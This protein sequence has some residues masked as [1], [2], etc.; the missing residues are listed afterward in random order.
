[1]EFNLES[2]STGSLTDRPHS[3]S[4]R[5]IDLTVYFNVAPLS[6]MLFTATQAS[7]S[8]RQ[9]N[10]CE[11]LKGNDGETFDAI[12][13]RKLSVLLRQILKLQFL[14]LLV[15]LGHPYCCFGPSRSPQICGPNDLH[16][17]LITTGAVG[18]VDHTPIDCIC[19]MHFDKKTALEIG[20]EPLTTDSIWTPRC[21]RWLQTNH[22]GCHGSQC[23][24]GRAQ[25][26]SR[27]QCWY[28]RCIQ[29]NHEKHNQ[30]SVSGRMSP[31]TGHIG[32]PT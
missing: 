17:K 9:Q 13:C 10:F 18:A 31:R 29:C 30:S 23:K 21:D 7:T 8:I 16:Q 4:T 32:F 14:K 22:L 26:S 1:M 12:L 3:I 15:N 28:C 11:L 19:N 2:N 5:C 25:S 27:A 20:D 24:Q 6:H